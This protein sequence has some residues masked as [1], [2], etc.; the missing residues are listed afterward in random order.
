MANCRSC[1]AKIRWAKTLDGKSIPLNEPP[2]KRFVL[3]GRMGETANL[4]PTYLTHFQTCPESDEYRIDF[5][6]EQ[7]Y[8]GDLFPDFKNKERLK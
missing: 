4:V 2:E 8:K 7:K 6:E 3:M 5:R 1:G